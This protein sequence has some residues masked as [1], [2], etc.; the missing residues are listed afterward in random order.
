[1]KDASAVA[2]TG[3]VKMHVEGHKQIIAH[4]IV[5]GWASGDIMRKE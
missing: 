2:A 3:T 5:Q 4:Y 1:M